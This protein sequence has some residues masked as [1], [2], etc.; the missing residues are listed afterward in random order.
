MI[1]QTK[2]PMSVHGL[3][4]PFPKQLCQF[5]I[6]SASFCNLNLITLRPP[7]SLVLVTRFHVAR[8]GVLALTYLV[9][10][11]KVFRIAFKA[12]SC[13]THA[14]MIKRVSLACWI[15]GKLPVY[16]TAIGSLNSLAWCVLFII[17][18]KRYASRI[19]SNGESGLF[20]HTP[21]S[22]ETLSLKHHFGGLM[23]SLL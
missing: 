12:I 23:K 2:V 8:S 3:M 21:S 13:W 17:D 1:R 9:D 6:N 16:P 20:Y 11:A 14:S 18:C 15:T 7:F 10:Y 19:N 4:Q 22:N 5:F